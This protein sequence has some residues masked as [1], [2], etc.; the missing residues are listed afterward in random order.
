MGSLAK[1]SQKTKFKKKTYDAYVN[2]QH[3]LKVVIFSI[4]VNLQK[5]CKFTYESYA[6]LFYFV[7]CFTFGNHLR[8]KSLQK[9]VPEEAACGSFIEEF[10]AHFFDVARKAAPE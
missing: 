3:I 2:L 7:F 10:S 5:C 1:H 6:F 8:S 4:F 9:R